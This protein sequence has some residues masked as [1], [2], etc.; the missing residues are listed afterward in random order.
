MNNPLG[1]LKFETTGDFI[2]FKA[3]KPVKLRV[4]SINPLIS[5]N[6]YTNK[7]TGEISV[8][9]KYGFAVWNYT[10]GRA[11]ILNASPSIAQTIHKLHIDPDYDEDI[12]KL[13]IKIT[14][15][16][17]MLERRYEVNVLPKAQKLTAEQETAVAELDGKLDSI[18]KN[19]IRADRFNNGETKKEPEYGEADIPPEDETEGF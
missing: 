5:N 15:T 11:M 8:S 12:T 18:I 9:T 3:D 10:E 13:D 1:N 2:K 4:L 7:E 14:P 19:G 17:E 16:G 6:E